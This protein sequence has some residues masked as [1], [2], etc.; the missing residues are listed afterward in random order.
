GLEGANLE[1]LRIVLALDACA[2][3]PGDDGSADP[4]PQDGARLEFKINLLLDLVG[5]LLARQTAVPEARPLTLLAGGLAWEDAA[6]PAVAAMVRIE[7]F[8]TPRYPRPL[9]L[10]GRVQAVEP[11]GGGARVQVALLG[12]SAPVKERLERLIFVRHRRSVAQSRRRS[13]R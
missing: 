4:P 12:L 1:L 3:D 5:Q 6:P 7:I 10:H 8:F 9:V 13:G 11:A 2:A